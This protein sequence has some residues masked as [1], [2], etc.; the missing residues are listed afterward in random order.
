MRKVDFHST[1]NK[2][3]FFNK[4]AHLTCTLVNKALLFERFIMMERM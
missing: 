1:F 2:D 4:G 3:I